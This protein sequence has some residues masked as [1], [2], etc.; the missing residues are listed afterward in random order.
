MKPDWVMLRYARLDM[1]V[2]MLSR[3]NHSV[4]GFFNL[5]NIDATI[6]SSGVMVDDD[7]GDINDFNVGHQSLEEIDPDLS[8]YAMLLR[9]GF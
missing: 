1:F 8:L 9:V 2:T 7:L 5:I 6:F 4:I 3:K